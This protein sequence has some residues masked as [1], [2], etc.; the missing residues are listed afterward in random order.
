MTGEK[1]RKKPTFCDYCN[2]SAKEVGPLIEGPGSSGNNRRPG[3]ESVFICP[4]CVEACME[5]IQNE[6]LKNPQAHVPAKIPAPKDIVAMLNEHIIGQDKPKKILAVAVNNHYKRLIDEQKIRE[7]HLGHR[8]PR[9]DLDTVS[10]GKSNVL[11]F[12]PTGSGKT[13]LCQTLAKILDVPFAIGDATTITEAG[14]V[15][16][17]VE[18]LLLRLLRAADGD[19][20]K[21]QSGIIYIDEI[22]KIGKTSQNVSITRDV[23]GEGVQQ[24]LLKMLEGTVANVPPQGGRKHPEQQCIQLD[25]SN[26]LFICGGAFVGLEDI[27]ARR[28][29]KKGFGFGSNPLEDEENSKRD[30][31]LQHVI[32]DDLIE[33][34]MIPEFCGRVPVKAALHDLDENTLVR[35]LTE[36]KDALLRQYK[37]LFRYNNA[38]LEF[39]EDSIREIARKALKNNTG[40]RALRGVMEELM[41]EIQYN[42]P[43]DV[44]GMTYIITDKVVLGDETPLA[45]SPDT[46]EAA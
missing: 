15:G 38:K 21:A 41:L 37:K 29:G 3:L 5:V 11:L 19:V 42:L 7:V 1:K 30:Y 6:G 2:Q 17:D 13:L 10:I 46:K 8:Q 40:A 23:S 18:N 28:T 24:A 4:K 12:G 25:T 20:E 31:L 27:V 44:K 33:Y 26:I 14:Y 43:E 32:D 34:G 9:D 35:V 39:T 16:E 36:P 22:D 45:V